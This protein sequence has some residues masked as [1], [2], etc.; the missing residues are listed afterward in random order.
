MSS[1][2]PQV[3][4]GTIAEKLKLEGQQQGLQI[5]IPI[6]LKIKF[7]LVGEALMN[8]IACIKDAAMLQALV[9]AIEVAKSVEELRVWLAQRNAT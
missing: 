2:T 4:T 8:E 9:E 7:G 1:T 5:G 3:E 6:A